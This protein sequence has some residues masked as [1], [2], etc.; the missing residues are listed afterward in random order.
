MS[1]LLN[2]PHTA[3][4][5][6]I[7]ETKDDSGGQIISSRSSVL[8]FGCLVRGASAEEQARFAQQQQIITNVVATIY[9]AGAMP[10]EFVFQGRVLRIKGSRF[11]AGVGGIPS[12]Y[13][14]Y[15]EYVPGVS[16]P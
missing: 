12:W 8:S 16:V 7:V 2:P 1:L 15:C 3:E 13:E 11:Q 14:Y 6:R 5:R 10:G 9:D 4:H